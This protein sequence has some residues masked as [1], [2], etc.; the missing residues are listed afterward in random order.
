[1]LSRMHQKLGTA[2]FIISIVALIAALGGTAAALTSADKNLVKSESK[3]F[4]K[5]F[6]NQ[7]SKK[8]AKPGPAGAPGAKGD[9]GAA[10]AAGK[11]GAPGAAGAPGAD[12]KTPTITKFAN[13]KLGCTEGGVEVKLSPTEVAACNGVKGEK[14]EPWT[15]GGTLPAG[16]TETGAWAMYGAGYR[17][18][19]EVNPTV[20]QSTP[21]KGPISF[22]IPTATAPQSVFLSPSET[23]APGCPGIVDGLPTADPGNLCVY[24]VNNFNFIFNPGF[25]ILDP[26]QN[27]AVGAGKSGAYIFGLCESSSCGVH[28]VWAVTAATA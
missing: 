19:P 4:S 25:Q 7:F 20:F 17:A 1:M 8:Y 23:S 9:A 2:G 11:D 24:T 3:K 5:Q 18:E 14:G 6:S 21:S 12:G 15:A 10:G 27:L 28:G 16:E 13:A 26:S 22:T